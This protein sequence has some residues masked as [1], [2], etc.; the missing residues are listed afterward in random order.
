[1]PEAVREAR[2]IID[3]LGAHALGDLLDRVAPPVESGAGGS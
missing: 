2:A 1:V 3:Q